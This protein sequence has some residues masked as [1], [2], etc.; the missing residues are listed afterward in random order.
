MG[1]PKVVPAK[2]LMLMTSGELLEYEVP[3]GVIEELVG[4]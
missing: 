2:F 3:G 1:S 4:D